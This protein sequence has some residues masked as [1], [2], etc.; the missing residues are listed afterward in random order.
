MMVKTFS[1]ITLTSLLGTSNSKND[2]FEFPF[3]SNV[4]GS[5]S[6]WLMILVT[7]VTAIFLYRTLRSQQ[8]TQDLQADLNRLHHRQHKKNIMPYF[9][10]FEENSENSPSYGNYTTIKLCGANAHNVKIKNIY[11]SPVIEE[12]IP[13]V[14]VNSNLNFKV[15]ITHTTSGKLF[16]IRGFSLSKVT[17]NQGKDVRVNLL[18]ITCEDSERTTYS[19]LFFI[20]NENFYFT[21]SEEVSQE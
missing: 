6:D 4:W 11:V 16:S 19:Q 5:V 15:S 20:L 7:G 14:A 1:H 12:E 3:I 18:S 10:V 13:F 21:S 9:V 8:K 17:L 2:L